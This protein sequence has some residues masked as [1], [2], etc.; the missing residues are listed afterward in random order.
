MNVTSSAVEY[1]HSYGVTKTVPVNEVEFVEYLRKGAYYKTTKKRTT[2]L[3]S[4]C[5]QG[6]PPRSR[7]TVGKRRPGICPAC[8]RR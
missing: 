4:I 2:L 1:K 5:E 3:T 8:L 7:E 6:L